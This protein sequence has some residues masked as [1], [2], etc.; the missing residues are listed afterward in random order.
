MARRNEHLFHWLFDQ[1]WWVSI[2]IGAVVFVG[3]RFVLPAL[4]IKNPVLKPIADMAPMFWPFALFFLYPAGVSVFRSFH[5]RRRLD[6]QTGI[7]SIRELPWRE[8]EDLLAEA[9]RRSGWRVT[10]TGSAGPDGGVDLIIERDGDRYLVQCKQ[11]RNIKVGVRVVRE[12]FG[13]MTAE[14]ASGVVIVTSGMF[15]QDARTFAAKK[16]ID[17]VEGSQ[18]VKMIRS[19]QG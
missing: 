10:K 13:V 8:F 4:P 11:W 3:L 7:K 2:I 16:P 6:R 12:M 18:L 1:P 15:T 17:L 5:G 9:Y 19:V 14:G